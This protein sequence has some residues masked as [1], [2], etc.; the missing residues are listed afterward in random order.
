M[1]Q[2]VMR[3]N[4]LHLPV[5]ITMVPVGLEELPMLLATDFVR[6]IDS[7]NHWERLFGVGDMPTAERMM[8]TFWQ[9]YRQWF[10]DFQPFARAD[11]GTLPL[12]RTLPIY[13]H[14]D[15]GTHYKRSALMV[16]QWQ[17]VLGKGTMKLGPLQHGVLGS[18]QRGQT[19]STRMLLAV[20]RKDPPLQ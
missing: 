3:D 14:G 18:N 9:Q 1:V 13:V 10:P 20:M 4:N 7:G 19:L 16:V 8:T 12:N 6:V 17:S 15:E 11:A 2:R 5:P